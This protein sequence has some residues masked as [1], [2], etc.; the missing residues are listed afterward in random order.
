MP[1]PATPSEPLAGPDQPQF[2]ARAAHPALTLVCLDPALVVDGEPAGGGYLADEVISS[3]VVREHCPACGDARLHLVLRHAR[4][5]RSH[6]YC[7]VCTRCFDALGPDGASTLT[8]P[9]QSIA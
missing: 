4:V 1:P 8:L 6:L 5:I 9:S 7:P 2:A 3:G